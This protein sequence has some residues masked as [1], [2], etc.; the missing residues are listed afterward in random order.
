MTDIAVTPFVLEESIIEIDGDDYAA[1]IN[2]IAVIP[3]TSTKVFSGL[4]R[5]A[6]F[7]TTVVDSW[8]CTITLAQDWEAATSLANY[9]FDPANEGQ[10]KAA[11][12]RPVAE[13]VGFTVNLVIV[14]PTIGGKGGDYTTA[15]VELGVSGRPVQV[16][17]VTPPLEF[18]DA[19]EL[20]G[21]LHPAE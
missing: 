6:K 19:S 2:A 9:L 11:T 20:I 16:A 4:K 5:A 12:V 3:K 1:A 10:I 13:G 14:P 18:T 21:T 17:A 7:T 8:S 15:D